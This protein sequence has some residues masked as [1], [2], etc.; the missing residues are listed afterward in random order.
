MIGNSK[1]ITKKIYIRLRCWPNKQSKLGNCSV[2]KLFSIKLYSLTVEVNHCTS[3][4][5]SQLEIKKCARSQRSTFDYFQS[6]NVVKM[7]QC[8]AFFF[9]QFLTSC[10]KHYSLDALFFYC[11]KFL[12]GI[13]HC[14]ASVLEDFI[15]A[16]YFRRTK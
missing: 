7:G 12:L 15:Y 6:L 4:H 14:K 16:K 5:K 1:K 2:N 9:C 10:P 3:F 8:N 13:I 11:K